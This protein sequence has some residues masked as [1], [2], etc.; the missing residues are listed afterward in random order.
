[1]AGSWSHSTALR[2]RNS[3]LTLLLTNFVHDLARDRLQDWIGKIER[4]AVG[5]DLNR[6][7]GRIHD[8]LTSRAMRQML[9]ELKADLCGCL[10][11]EVIAD[12]GHEV[13]TAN[14]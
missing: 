9:L 14:Q 8:Y 2:E 4:A 5:Y 6:F 7:P 10:S 13:C 11:L 12:L 1:M 3:C